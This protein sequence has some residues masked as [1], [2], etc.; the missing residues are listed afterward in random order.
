[1][2]AKSINIFSLIFLIAVVV[3]ATQP[4]GSVLAKPAAEIDAHAPP[5]DSKSFLQSYGY[6]EYA[7]LNLEIGASEEQ[8]L[9]LAIKTYQENFGISPTGILDDETLS[10]MTMPRC[11]NPDIYG[12]V[13]TMKH[14]RAQFDE[15]PAPAGRR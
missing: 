14:R 15:K 1:M 8:I 4:G 11:G 9:E 6:L 12:G 5:F 13:N 2:A 10:L 3:F 7:R